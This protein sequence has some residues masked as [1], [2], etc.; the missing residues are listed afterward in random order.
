M[1]SHCVFFVFLKTSLITQS[2]TGSHSKLLQI[3]KL[4]QSFVHFFLFALIT[5]FLI[6]FSLS[7][8]FNF[9]FIFFYYYCLPIIY[10]PLFHIPLFYSII[11][12][13]LLFLFMSSSVVPPLQFTLFILLYLP[14]IYIII[15]ELLKHLFIIHIKPIYVRQTESVYKTAAPNKNDYTNTHT[16]QMLRV[17]IV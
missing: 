9:L 2:T 4:F 14:R 12:V 5:P 11:V 7:S 13:Y 8:T 15:Y 10:I 16:I 1:F 3:S 6:S 17:I